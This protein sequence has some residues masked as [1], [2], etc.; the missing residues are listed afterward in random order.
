M[1]FT[2]EHEEIQRTLKRF[3]DEEINPHV[4]EWEAAEIFPAHQVFKRLGE[5]GALRAHMAH[6]EQPGDYG[7]AIRAMSE[8]S[9]VCGATGFMVWCHEVCGVYMEQSGNPALTGERLARHNSGHTLG[10]TGMSNP[11]KTFAGIETFLLH[12]RTVEGGCASSWAT[13]A[14]MP[15][16]RLAPWSAS[17]IAASSRVRWCSFSAI[18]VAHRR[19]QSVVAA[20]VSTV[21]A[22][23]ARPG[24]RR[25][26]PSTTA[27][28]HRREAP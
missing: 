28:R 25:A 6:G 7:L 3:I 1:Q 13:T 16:C 5:L 23:T 26:H 8:V 17:P 24:C 19:S 21:I 9:R 4:D 18:S 11:M 14:L 2:H 20:S 22:P 12:A 27:V 10:A 15:R